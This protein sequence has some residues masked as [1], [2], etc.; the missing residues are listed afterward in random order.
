MNVD[1]L[2]KKLSEAYTTENL[3]RISLILI[4]L[5]QDKKFGTLKEIGQIIDDERQWDFE[6]S[7]KDFNHMMKLYHPDLLETLRQKLNNQLDSKDIDSMLESSHILRLNKIEEISE[8]FIDHEDIDYS[9]VYDWDFGD[10]NFNIQAGPSNPIQFQSDNPE[11]NSGLNFYDAL[12]LRIYGK[13][14]IDLP[15]FYLEDLDELELTEAAINDLNGVEF[16]KHTTILDLSSNYIYNLLPFWTMQQIRQLNLS[17]NEISLLDGLENLN[18]LNIL[19]VSDNK[20]TDIGPIMNLR[21]LE[22]VNLNGN[23]I[24]VSQVEELRDLGVEVEYEE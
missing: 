4:Q 14:N 13:L 23:N 7:S 18:N 3:N 11:S 21:S 20:I 10:D 9:P 1:S 2:Y 8:N 19:D 5:F 15:Y 22:F 6:K 17:N 24:P 16:C 12:K